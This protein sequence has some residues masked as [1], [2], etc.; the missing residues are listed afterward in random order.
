MAYCE[1]ERQAVIRHAERQDGHFEAL[2]EISQAREEEGEKKEGEGGE[3][4]SDVEKKVMRTRALTRSLVI[5]KPRKECLMNAIHYSGLP[6]G[7][8]WRAIPQSEEDSRCPA[9]NSEEETAEHFQIFGKI[10]LESGVW[11]MEIKNKSE[12]WQRPHQQL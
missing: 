3:G 4:T 8:K 1:L 11:T 6:I 9:Y 12:S 5:T 2:E 7:K 10:T